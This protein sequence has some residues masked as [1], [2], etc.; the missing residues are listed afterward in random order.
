MPTVFCS[1]TES[2]VWFS[3]SLVVSLIVWLS[4]VLTGDVWAQYCVNSI[5]LLFFARL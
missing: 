2:S 3:V 1:N 4:V 5:I